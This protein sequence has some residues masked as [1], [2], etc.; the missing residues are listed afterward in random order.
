M[1]N[2]GGIVLL[3]A[4][5]HIISPDDSRMRAWAEDYVR[6]D[7]DM[8]WIMGNYVEADNVNLNGHIFPL[9]DLPSAIKTLA[10]KP[11]NMLHADEYIVGSYVGSHLIDSKG[12]PLSEDDIE[13]MVA[14][15][16]DEHPF[17]QAVAGMWHKLFPNEYRAIEKA[18]KSG[19]L[20]FSMECVPETVTCPDCEHSAA[21]AGF[22]DDTYC[23]HMQGVTAPKILNK[24]TFG[25]GAIVI[26]PAKPGWQR[27][28]VKQIAELMRHDP[29][30]A[31]GLYA[32]A[33]QLRPDMDAA[34]WEAVMGEVLLLEAQAY[35]DRQFSPEQRKK[36]SK[37]GTAMPDGS[38]PI[39]SVSD[40]KNAIQAVGRAPADKRGAVKSHIKKRARALGHPELI[41]EGW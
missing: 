10:N 11:L 9:G 25:G 8:K 23:D 17:V 28:E 3:G 33:Q 13:A 18:H 5:A 19:Q 24:P 35:M 31:E 22:E 4:S 37:E 29:E 40:L 14:A 20:F 30:H 27:A 1:T 26:P 32:A 7:P 34:G 21:F 39:G 15:E 6:S 2:N 12:D 16:T 36:M 41:P 38:Y